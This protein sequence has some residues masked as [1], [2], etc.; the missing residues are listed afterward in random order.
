MKDEIEAGL[1]NAME[2][3][4]S[5]EQAKQSFINAGYNP[6]EV[7]EAGNRMSSY[8]GASSIMEKVESPKP[9]KPEAPYQENKINISRET[10]TG[11]K[12]KILIASIIISLIILLG[13]ISYL[14]YALFFA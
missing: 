1:Q 4:E 6:Q 9:E 11:G 14:I 2:R 5:L 13:S 12:K 10:D 7:A 8:G 3:G